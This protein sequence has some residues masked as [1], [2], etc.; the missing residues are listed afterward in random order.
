[1][2]KVRFYAAARQAAGNLD[3]QDLAAGSLC[4]LTAMLRHTHGERMAQ[5]LARC[6]FLVDGMAV[7]DRSVDV[8]LPTDTTADVLPPSAEG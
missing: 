4:E 3:E 5:V 1:M 8:A 6:S 7:A 2:A